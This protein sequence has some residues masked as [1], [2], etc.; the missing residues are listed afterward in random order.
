MQQ[1]L[2]VAND[3][4]V[5]SLFYLQAGFLCKGN[6]VLRLVRNCSA[7]VPVLIKEIVIN[8]MISSLINLFI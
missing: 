6:G 8:P 2:A 1:Y 3:N 5:R 4:I 7:A